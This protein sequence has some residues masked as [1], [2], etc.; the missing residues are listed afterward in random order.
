MVVSNMA[1]LWRP[2]LSG[3]CR[4]YRSLQ[5]MNLGRRQGFS[6]HGNNDK[7]SSFETT[8]DI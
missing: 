2:F 8:K 6:S 4:S 5:A 1:E 7:I 3:T